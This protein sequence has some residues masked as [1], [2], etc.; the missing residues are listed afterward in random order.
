MVTIAATSDPADLGA[1]LELLHLAFRAHEG[2]IDPP[3]AVYRETAETLAA[4]LQS[5]TLLI[6]RDAE[7]RIIG[8]IFYRQDSPDEG[9]IGRLAVLP[10]LQRRGIASDLVAASLEVARQDGVRRVGLGVRIELAENIA[11]FERH[12]FA[13]VRE[14][15]HDGYDRT[16]N[17]HMELSLDGERA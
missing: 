11:F 2:R 16:T 1:V 3:S 7:G 14:E 9:Y 10:E 17:Y 13:I 4:K 6:A 8:C 12:G 15:R 5:E